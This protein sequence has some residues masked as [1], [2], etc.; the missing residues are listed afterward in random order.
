M[1]VI[2]PHIPNESRPQTLSRRRPQSSRLRTKIDQTYSYFAKQVDPLIASCVANFLFSQPIDI[3]GAMRAYFGDLQN[4]KPFEGLVCYEPKKEQK[5][6]FTFNLGPILSTVVDAIAAAQPSDVRLFIC[7]ELSKNAAHFHHE[8]IDISTTLKSVRNG[9]S[10]AQESADTVTNDLEVSSTRNKLSDAIDLANTIATNIDDITD[11]NIAIS[12]PIIP[13]I[14]DLDNKENQEPLIPTKK[15]GLITTTSSVQ[16]ETQLT[17]TK[18]AVI[19]NIQISILGSSGGGKTSIVNALQG[20][21]DMKVK[22]S[23]GFKPT[24]MMLGENINVKFYDLGGGLKI[25][26]IWGE[27]YHDVHAVIYVFDSSLKEEE[28]KESIALFQSTISHPLLIN[29][30]VLIVANKQDKQHALPIKQLMESLDGNK[31]KNN[32][33]EIIE[34]SSFSS[35]TVRNIFNQESNPV[36]GALAVIPEVC[37]YE[38]E[39]INIYMYVYMYTHVYPYIYI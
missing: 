34:C 9:S 25:R 36:E 13:I 18:Q 7:D 27:Y 11:S 38:F 6:Y 32:G 17:T 10:D 39:Y 4:I 21:F 14:A 16:K 8:D 5:T 33:L 26:G 23:L 20:R 24:T 29:K 3:I 35:K 12:K 31:L 19:K 28:L 15:Q 2:Q 37:T 30:P 1:E 22:P